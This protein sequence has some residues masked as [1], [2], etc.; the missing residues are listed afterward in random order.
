M[1]DEYELIFPSFAFSVNDLHFFDLLLNTYD[2]QS[3]NN[4]KLDDFYYLK[5]VLEN[6]LV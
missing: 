2:Y 1:L 5:R 4:I 6:I 3:R